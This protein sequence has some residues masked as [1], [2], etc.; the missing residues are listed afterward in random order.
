[1]LIRK[2]LTGTKLSVTKCVLSTIVRGE[3]QKLRPHSKKAFMG[4]KGNLHVLI[5]PFSSQL[6][7]QEYIKCC[8][9]I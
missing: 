8:Q 1:M 6:S 9:F 7:T 2:S 3:R 4:T 5:Y